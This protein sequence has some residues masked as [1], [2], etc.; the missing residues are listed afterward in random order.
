LICDTEI[1]SG[2]RYC[3][4]ETITPFSVDSGDRYLLDLNAVILMH[5]GM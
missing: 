5:G 3:A 1:T 4:T 2:H